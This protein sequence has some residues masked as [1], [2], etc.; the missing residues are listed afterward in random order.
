ME[1]PLRIPRP[2]LGLANVTFSDQMDRAGEVRRL[3]RAVAF[4]G[5]LYGPPMKIEVENVSVVVH[6]ATVKLVAFVNGL[7]EEIA[8]DV[9]R[10]MHL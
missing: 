1:S 7:A 5:I 8:E 2:G 3:T 6:F 4:L 10:E 9:R